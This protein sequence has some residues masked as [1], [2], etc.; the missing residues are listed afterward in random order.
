MKVDQKTMA[1]HRAALLNQACKLFRRRGIDGVA[2]AEI[3]GAAGLTH[4]AFYGH[5]PSKA[6]LAAEAC[7]HSLER[8]AEHWRKLAGSA[9]RAGADPIGAIVDSYL[10]IGARDTR[11]SSCA[12]TTLGHEASR[13]PELHPA[14][15]TGVD[16]LLL[17]LQEL[18]AK[19]QPSAPPAAH[20]ESALAALAAMNGGLNLARLLTSDPD[21]SAAALAA[22]AALAKRA[23]VADQRI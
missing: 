4:G 20:A 7:R 23:V 17:V 1:A 22:A 16:A 14:M 2:V 15:A 21:R 5:F 6:A 19:R 13:D 9:E 8:A 18:I 12:L 11:E 10:T 3:A